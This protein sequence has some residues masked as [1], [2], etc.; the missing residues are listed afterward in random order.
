[1]QLT[2]EY[3]DKKIATQ[4]RFYEKSQRSVTKEIKT[5][6]QKQTKALTE[7][8]DWKVG[9]I[10]EQYGSITGDIH[11]IKKQLVDIQEKVDKI[12]VMEMDIRTIKDDVGFIK[13]ELEVVK[14]IL[15]DPDDQKEYAVLQQRVYALEH[16]G[17]V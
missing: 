8:F 12:D 17:A 4:Q 2:K 5:E 6:F 3:L 9:V 1:M 11:S 13:V 15:T 10:G 16:R 14:D 7:H